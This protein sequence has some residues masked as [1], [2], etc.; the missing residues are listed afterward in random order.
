MKKLIFKY[1]LLSLF[2]CCCFF[3]ID[4]VYAQE[5]MSSRGFVYNMSVGIVNNGT[6]YYMSPDKYIVINGQSTINIFARY[7]RGFTGM[8]DNGQSQYEVMPNNLYQRVT[9]CSDQNFS[10]GANISNNSDI[11]FQ[12]TNIDCQFY[13]SSYTGHIVFGTSK[14]KLQSNSYLDNSLAFIVNS[15]ASVGFMALE[16]SLEP[17]PNY[18]PYE[19]LIKQNDEIIDALNEFTTSNGNLGYKIDETNQK[20]EE[21]NQA[22]KDTNDTIKDSDTSEASDSAGSFFEGFSTDTHGLTSII[23]APLELIGNITS[24][25]CSPIALDIPF[26]DGQTLSLPCMSAIY[27]DFFGD[28][29]DVYQII[30][31]GIVAYW[32]CVRIFNLVKDFKN[33]DHD[34]VE[35]MDL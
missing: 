25:S 4:K 7:E 34:E 11:W 24:S 32:V 35:V 22:I 18:T 33:P 15:S 27:E 29:F 21:T 13:G 2:T 1:F 30:T 17:F 8:N 12:N 14:V 3:G 10:V 20:L 5:V 23:T 26:L 6:N 28:F 9:F 31:F 19:T 16:Y